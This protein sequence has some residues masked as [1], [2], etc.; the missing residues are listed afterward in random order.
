MKLCV[1][2]A[3]ALLAIAGLAAA[4]DKKKI[5]L[6]VQNT[7]EG[8]EM[9]APVTAGKDQMWSAELD[10]KDGFF[11]DTAAKVS[12]RVDNFSVEVA[13]ARLEDPL[14]NKWP[15]KITDV[16]KNQREAY[17]KPKDDGSPGNWKE[18]RVKSEEPK[19]KIQSLSGRGCM[20][21]ITLVDS[22]DGKRDLIQYFVISSEVLYTVTVQFDESGYNKYF[23]KEGQFILNNIKRC[24]VDKK[25]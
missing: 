7:K 14:R 23:L 22:R 17:V 8:V 6:F 21:H 5:E 13:V 12:H 16:A 18:C 3:L 10:P 20:H 1:R 15:D 19:A 24:K 9:R 25:K 2:G 11:K 4:Q